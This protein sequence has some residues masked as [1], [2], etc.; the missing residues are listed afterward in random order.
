MAT[1]PDSGRPDQTLAE[2]LSGMTIDE[3]DALSDEQ[4]AELMGATAEEFATEP[5]W[6]WRAAAKAATQDYADRLVS[7]VESG[8][9]RAVTDPDEIRRRLGGR[10]RVGGEP[11]GGPS[12]QVRVR[13]TSR[14]R[15]ELE[16]IAKEQG[17]L[18]SEVSREALDEYVARHAG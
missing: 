17:R 10:P 6:S 5:R 12:T 7:A 9:A 8:Q 3:I 1:L 13:V 11:G 14:T 2:R 4:V 15:L 18:L 16:R